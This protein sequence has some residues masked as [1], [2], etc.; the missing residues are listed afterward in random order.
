MG[1]Y[2]PAPIITKALEIKIISKIIKPTLKALKKINNTYTGFLYVGLMIKNNEPY[3]IEYNIRMGD[4]EC[5]VILPRLKTDIVK[6]FESAILN[7]LKKIS[8]KWKKEK[9]MTI[10]LCSKGYPKSYKKNLEINNLDKIKLNKSDF[11]YHAGTKLENNQLISNGGRVL[12]FTSLG[13]NF[14][15]IRKNIILKIKKLNWKNGF[16]R[17]DIGW[18]AIN[19]Q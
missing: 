11:V 14:L 8:I 2:S 18:K 1:A 9:C 12:N 3:L 19:K 17:K 7:K 13:K 15:K 5:Q 6:I 10:V 4:P 16:F